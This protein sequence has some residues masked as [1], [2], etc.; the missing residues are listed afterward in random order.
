MT[1]ERTK[2]TTAYKDGVPY[3]AI[4]TGNPA[5]PLFEF[6][7]LADAGWIMVGRV[8][9]ENV[10]FCWTDDDGAKQCGYCKCL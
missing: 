6:P 8:G 3:H 9:E 10:Y 4:T 1:A 7:T 2:T 5:G